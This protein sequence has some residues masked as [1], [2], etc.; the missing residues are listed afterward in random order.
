MDLSMGASPPVLLTCGPLVLHVELRHLYA[1]GREACLSG[2]QTAILALLM[3]RAGSVV[4]RDALLAAMY[5]SPD[6]EPGDARQVLRN[7]MMML[8]RAL[9]QVGCADTI[10][11]MVDEGYLI[12]GER[13]VARLYTAEQARIADAAVAGMGQG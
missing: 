13:R 1:H 4:S 3:R 9:A 11:A 2:R 10:R 8:R 12:D 7:V 6:E 5:P